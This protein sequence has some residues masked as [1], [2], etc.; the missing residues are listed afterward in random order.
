[1]KKQ[2]WVAV[3]LLMIA[4]AASREGVLRGANV[5]AAAAPANDLTQFLP[6]GAGVAVID[7]KRIINSP[8]W[9]A[10]TAQP[11]I[12]ADLDKIQ[13][14]VLQVGVTLSDIDS[15]ALSFSKANLDQSTVAV[16]GGFDQATLLEKLRTNEK[17]KLSSEKYK[18]FEIDTAEK[19]PAKTG[20]PSKP[21][22]KTSSKNTVSFTFFDSKTAVLGTRD[23]VRAAIDTKMGARPSIAQNTQLMGALNENPDAAIRLALNVSSDVAGK[24][25]TSDLPLPDFS[26]IR[27]IWAS[28]DVSSGID[29]IATLRNDSA[30]H[31][32]AIAE[33]LN[34]LLNM[35]RGYLGAS[36]DPKYSGLADS[37]KS[38]NI[39]GNDVDVKI[40]GSISMDVLKT[41]LGSGQPKKP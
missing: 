1:M 31:A 35:V 5:R 33:R 11:K 37:L 22:D 6:D 18:D 3:A 15:I 34:G 21:D 20:D 26:S 25:Q 17:V 32:K 24:L 7:V 4:V 9:A 28:I 8:V 19:I 27:M 30:E 2:I 39:V 40:T 23:A 16:T 14:D 41:L 36:G 10:L 13:A 12:K 38:I 29:L